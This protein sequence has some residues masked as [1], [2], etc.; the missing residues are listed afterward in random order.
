MSKIP[1]CIVTACAA[2]MFF[3]IPAASDA[4]TIGELLSSG[5]EVEKQ[6]GELLRNYGLIY[7]GASLQRKCGYLRFDQHH[8]FMNREETIRKIV[9]DRVD[10]SSVE[11]VEKTMKEETGNIPCD[12]DAHRLIIENLARAVHLQNELASASPTT[13]S[14]EATNR[15]REL[16]AESKK[17]MSVNYTEM[18]KAFADSDLYT[19]EDTAE[20]AIIRAQQFMKEQ[21]PQEA[22]LILKNVLESDWMLFRPHYMVMTLEKSLGHNSEF[23]KHR[24]MLKSMMLSITGS[25][26]SRTTAGTT[27]GKSTATAWK[28]I[29]TEEIAGIALSLNWKVQ[30]QSRIEENGHFYEK[31][32]A[33]D[34]GGVPM[35]V[36]FNTDTPSTA[37]KRPEGAKPT[38]SP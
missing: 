2:L 5:S 21:K 10:A 9:I 19:T 3:A 12:V 30:R 34:G 32:E 28:V 18:R 22:L 20:A 13:G 15:Y 7:A 31:L 14:G 36:F 26:D 27:D 33:E 8:D 24:D 11:E 23:I 29:R 4:K 16:L 35:T 38:N 17:G 37:K 25:K 1:S 6:R